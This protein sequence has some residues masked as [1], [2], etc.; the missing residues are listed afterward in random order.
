DAA[1]LETFVDEVIAENPGPAEQFRGGK[2]GV[3]G[4]LVGQVMKKTKGA[5]NPQEVQRLLRERLT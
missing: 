5:A 2:E 3:I 1:E 4:F